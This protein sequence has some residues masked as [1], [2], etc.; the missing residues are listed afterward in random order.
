MD[1]TDSK[2]EVVKNLEKTKDIALKRGYAL[3]IGH[4]GAEGGL[5][6]AQAI[7]ETYE[8]FQNQGIKFVTVSE[9]KNIIY[10]N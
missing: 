7:A 1:S 4:V 8:D 5:I 10:G 2:A 3:C 6:T 9:L